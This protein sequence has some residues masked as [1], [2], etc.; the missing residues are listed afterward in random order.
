MV[1]ALLWTRQGNLLSST[2]FNDSAWKPTLRKP[3]IRHPDG[4]LPT[5]HDTRH[6]Y[7][8]KTL[9]NGVPPETVALWVGDSVQEIRRTHHHLLDERVEDH[10]AHVTRLTARPVRARVAA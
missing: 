4:T 3:G 5:F 8:S 1:K 10:R 7:I 2:T 9:Q 6:T